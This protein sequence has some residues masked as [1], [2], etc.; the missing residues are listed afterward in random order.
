MA[1]DLTNI[2]VGDK[3]AMNKEPSWPGRARID[4]RILVVD[5]L[6]P[7]QVTCKEDGNLVGGHIRAWKFNRKT[8]RPVG[9]A[10][11]FFDRAFIATDE[12]LL[13]HAEQ[14]EYAARLWSAEA[15]LQDLFN[16]HPNQLKLSLEQTEAL[17]KAWLEVK[18]LHK[19][20]CA[21]VEGG[22]A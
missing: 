10:A 15:D 16:K 20:P 18:A 22:A 19:Q 2:K 8:G 17:A 7:T 5:K 1:T 3:L 12:I 6:T 14:V 21:K 11:S 13:K 9:G 4:H